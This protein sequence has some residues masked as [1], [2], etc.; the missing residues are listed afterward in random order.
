MEELKL[1]SADQVKDDRVMESPKVETISKPEVKE[2][3]QQSKTSKL[4]PSNQDLDIFLLGGDSDDDPGKSKASIE[5]LTHL[6]FSLD[7]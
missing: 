7:S 1:K 4:S 2:Q 5:S 3:T 6:Q